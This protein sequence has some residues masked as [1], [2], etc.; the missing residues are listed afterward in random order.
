MVYNSFAKHP[1]NGTIGELP[2]NKGVEHNLFVEGN[3]KRYK[4]D[5]GT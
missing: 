4:F 5:K 2:F 3:H 1:E